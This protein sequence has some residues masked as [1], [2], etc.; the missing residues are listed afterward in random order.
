MIENECLV[1]VSA[2][3]PCIR[4]I[5]VMATV[6]YM[7][8]IELIFLLNATRLSIHSLGESLRS[9]EVAAAYEN[10]HV[11]PNTTYFV[12]SAAKAHFYSNATD[13]MMCKSAQE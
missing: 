3:R 4:C 11:C 12:I 7:M 6:G 9:F 10:R 13:A 1:D 2:T 8:T 5:F